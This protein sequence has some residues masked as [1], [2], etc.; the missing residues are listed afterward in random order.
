MDLLIK[1]PPVPSSLPRAAAKPSLPP[2][3]RRRWPPRRRRRPRRSTA[4]SK[5][6][7][8]STASE[9]LRDPQGLRRGVP[10]TGPGPGPGGPRPLRG[11]ARPAPEPVDQPEPKRRLL[12]A[13][14]K[15]D[16]P[17]TNGDDA[18]AEGREDGPNAAQGGERREASN[19][20]FRRDGSQWV[21][22]RELDNQLP[23][24]LPRPAPKEEDQSLVRRNKRMLGKLL[25]GTLEVNV[26]KTKKTYCKN[27]ECKKHTL[28]KVT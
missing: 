25:V 15:V 14:V 20:G 16:G 24:P 12:S 22:R 5:S 6:C 7:S 17:G 13:V 27:K 28:H 1:H 18:A 11:F 19:G 4:S 10:A 23:E 26:P 21:S 2:L 3:R 8:A 9:H